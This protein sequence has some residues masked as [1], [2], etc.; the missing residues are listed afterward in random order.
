MSQGDRTALR[1]HRPLLHQA[2]S[3]VGWAQGVGMAEKD[4][5][6]FSSVESGH[7]RS[8]G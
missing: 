8:V 3:L 1:G 6:L 5:A 2:R 4:G 7:T